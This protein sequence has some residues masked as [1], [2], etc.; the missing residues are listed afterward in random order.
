MSGNRSQSK[1]NRS[2]P[3]VYRRIQRSGQASYIVDVGLVDGKRQRHSFK[4]KGEADAFAEMKRTE[5]KNEGVSALALPQTTKL[6]AAKAAKLLT[7]HAVSLEE[8]AKYY[9]RHV[10]AY[11]NAPTIS[12]IV[13]RM[14]SEATKNARRTRTVGDLKNRLKA[15]AKDFPEVRI[16]ELTVEAIEA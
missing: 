15:F 10:I 6:D 14:V 11:R 5:R 1:R 16:S 13:D 4:T 9:V 12:V 8:A 2:F 3:N 7:P